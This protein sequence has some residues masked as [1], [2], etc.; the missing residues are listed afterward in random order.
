MRV[1]YHLRFFST[2]HSLRNAMRVPRIAACAIA[3]AATATVP[4]LPADAQG[5][6]AAR[7]A[8]DPMQEGLPLKPTRTLTFTTNRGHWMSSDVSRDGKS[9]VF[10]LLGDIYTMP[11]TGGQATPF[12][13]GMALDNQPRFSPDGKKIVFVSDRSGGYNLWTISVD[14]KDTVQITTGN[15]N[16]YESP[17]WTPDGKYIVATRGTKLWMFP[18]TGGSGIQLIRD[19]DAGA[20]GGR[21][22][23]GGADVARQ[24]GPAFGADARYLYFAQ[25]RGSWVYNTPLGDYDLMQ[26]DR[27]TGRVTSKENRWGS[28]FRPTLSP[29]G[30][31]LVYGTRY[32]DHTRLRIRNIE[33]SEEEWLTG[34]V[35]RDDQESR[36]T[37][38]VYP[39]MSFTPDSKSLVTTWDG[40]FWRVDIA[41]KAATEIPFEANVVQP[42]GPKVA[43]K[44]PISDSAQFVIKQIRDATPS[45]DGKRLAFVALDRLYV[46]DYPGGTPKRL[47]NSRFGEF[48]PTWSPDGRFIAFVTW[49]DTTG[50]LARMRSDG[51]GA[52]QRLTPKGGYWSG[53]VYSLSGSRIVASRGP[54]RGFRTGSGGRNGDIEE[55]VWIPAAGG[56]ATFIAN[57]AGNPF[58]TQRDTSRVFAYSG[59][60]GVY[61]MRWDG[62]DIKTII[63]ITGTPAPAAG[64]GGG[65]NAPS[66]SWAQISPNGQHILAQV[67]TDLFYIPD[68]PWPGGTEPTV[69]VGGTGA[70][71]DFPSKRLTDIGAQ[72]PQWSPDSKSVQWTIGNAHAV[73]DIAASYAYDDSVRKANPR[74]GAAGAG[75]GGGAGA[76]ADTTATGARRTTP[77]FKPVETRIR[78]MAPRDIPNSS[79]ALRNARIITMNGTS[80]IERGDIVVTNNRITAV[81]A[82]GSVTIPS[83]A[84]SIDMSGKTI[85]PGFVDTHAHLRVQNNIH[86][87]PVWSYAANLAYG[88]TAAR[89]PQTGSTDVLTYEDQEKAG[90]VLAPRIYSTGPGVFAGEN[91]RSLDNA[92][93]V[94]RRYAEYYDTKTIKQYQA[95]N[96]EV[97]QWII[98]AAN[99]LKLMPTTEG[100]LDVKMNLTEA[101]DGYSGHEHTIPTF[102]LQPD[103]I[104]L[105]AEAGTAYTP[106][107]VVAYGM[108]WAENYW[109]ERM[110]LLNDSKL[111]LFT[112]WSDLEGKILRRGGSSGAVT[113]M[114]QAGWFHDSQWAMA[115]IG[116]DIKKLIDAGGLAGVG[117]HGQQQGI[118]FHWEMW[119]IGMGTGMTTMDALRVATILGAQSL[120]LD[121]DIGS[122]ETG[123]LADLVIFDKNPL[124]DLQN[125]LAIANVMKNGRLYNANNL[126]EIYPRQVK[127]APFPWNEDDSPTRDKLIKR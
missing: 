87:D 66:A 83:G 32:V 117:S 122:I 84:R 107:I 95:G 44:Y 60:R 51:T 28:A 120:G 88:V 6:P 29:D 82:A 54:S 76:R 49:A 39:G 58:F 30:K 126:D 118:G 110:D 91:I 74:P 101:I 7:T 99:E 52:V 21:G 104:K 81:G 41:T 18:E 20:A 61:S 40:K 68:I 12:T 22:G 97:R 106:T 85:A 5:E 1:H 127:G 105:Y 115:Q 56:D 80:V 100:G 103:V 34:A 71:Q 78:V 67:G 31:W 35:Q 112:P 59:G 4:A 123:K 9:M 108:P 26:Y 86:R 65:G 13:R 75:A 27:E 55:L 38:D 10:D 36:A 14:K 121:G 15:T 111:Q 116:G 109:Y 17:V 62:T 113:T 93:T 53:P 8:R 119:S 48:E 124:D 3:L 102:P 72:F 79:V 77:A 16:N 63:R 92:R 73:Y 47:T 114:G 94:L 42:L 89:D 23:A 90:N 69:R 2:R 98:E 43:F 50:Y 70:T 45:P 33:T 46:M 96:R 125:S 24:E 11:M 57:A 64:G 37:L 25:R 19:T